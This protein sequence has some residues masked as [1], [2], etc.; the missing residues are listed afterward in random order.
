MIEYEPR[1]VLKIGAELGEHPLWSAAENCLYWLDIDRATI[2]RFDPASGENEAWPL[3]GQPGCF[4]FREDG[5]AV[6]A[7][8]D[9]FYIMDFATGDIRMAMPAAHDPAKMRYNDG[10]TDRRGRFWVSAVPLDLEFEGADETG[11]FRLDRN[12]VKRALFA[13]GVV[14]GTAFS[15]DGR[16][17]YRAETMSRQIFAHDYDAE[18]GEISNERIFAM[19]PTHLGGP[20]GAAVDSQ[21]GYWCALAA[22]QDGSA[23]TGGVARFTPDGRLDRYVRFPVPI[24]TMVAFGGPDLSTLYVTTARLERFMTGPVPDGAGDLYAFE[25]GFQGEPET[26]FSV[27]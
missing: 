7:I 5:T 4:M 24:V 16:T 21:G 17:M 10:R 27:F 20:D 6:I 19:V 22:P 15:P 23:E 14:N 12:G 2:N 26:K 11:W 8:Q 3:P 25:T 9:G 1:R 18:R 13:K